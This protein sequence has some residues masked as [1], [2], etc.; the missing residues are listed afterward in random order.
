VITHSAEYRSLILQL[1]PDIQ[2][3]RPC[4]IKLFSPM[5]GV[6]HKSKRPGTNSPIEED[7]EAE[8]KADQTKANVKQARE[9][10]KDAFK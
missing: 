8:G 2:I 3:L 10:F 6:P 4:D 5:P 9:K 7:T 1:R